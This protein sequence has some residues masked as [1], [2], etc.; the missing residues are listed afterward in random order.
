MQAH[1][2][3]GDSEG[4]GYERKPCLEEFSLE[5]VHAS[6]STC[7][8]FSLSKISSFSNSL[9]LR[10]TTSSSQSQFKEKRK[11]IHLPPGTAGTVSHQIPGPVYE[12][13][14]SKLSAPDFLKLPTKRDMEFPPT[15]ANLF[16]QHYSRGYISSHSCGPRSRSAHAKAPTQAWKHADLP[17]PPARSR[18]EGSTNQSALPADRP[19]R[20]AAS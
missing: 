18:W 8:R 3:A 6:I 14:T 13:P 2:Q 7:P 11:K 20:R 17:A 15:D 19:I 4:D 12:S 1:G 5:V 10:L 16:Y 9:L